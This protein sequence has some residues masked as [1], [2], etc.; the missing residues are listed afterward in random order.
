MITAKHN[1]FITTFFRYYVKMIIKRHFHAISISGDITEPGHALLMIGNHFSW[2][3]GFIAFYVNNTIL[4]KRFHV[5]ML[6]E[7][8]A[9]RKFFRG[10]GV[11]S[12]RTANRSVLDSLR[13]ASRIL[14]NPENILVIYPQG[15]IESSYAPKLKFGKGVVKILRGVSGSKP[16]ILFYAA[17]TDYFSNRK[18]GLNIYL[19]P[20]AIQDDF[21]TEEIEARY[22]DFYMSCINQQCQ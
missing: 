6:E 15:K 4:K 7:Q 16:Q 12:V 1:S 14:E 11:F 13:Y 5:M 8:L 20:F 10:I 9:K 17:L 2:W 21:K 19:A 22:N 18:P 3:D